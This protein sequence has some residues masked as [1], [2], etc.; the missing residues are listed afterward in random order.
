MDCMPKYLMMDHI[1]LGNLKIRERIISQPRRLN[2]TIQKKCKIH[3]NSSFLCLQIPYQH[4]DHWISRCSNYG[5]ME[6]KIM[7]GKH[8]HSLILS[9]NVR[10]YVHQA[11]LP[12]FLAI[13]SHGNSERFGTIFKK[14][15][16]FSWHESKFSS[17]DYFFFFSVIGLCE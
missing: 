12:H 16:L 10:Q 15:V 4:H 7:Q 3:C 11:T 9:Y 2:P 17:K 1:D 5:S 6:N 8:E 13:V 14:A